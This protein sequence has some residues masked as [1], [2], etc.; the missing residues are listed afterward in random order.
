M[1]RAVVVAALAIAALA[2]HADGYTQG[3]HSASV[4]R[5][6]RARVAPPMPRPQPLHNRAATLLSTLSAEDAVPSEPPRTGFWKFLPPKSE[7]K[8][9][10]PLGLIFFFILFSYTILRDTKDVLV[11][12]APKAGAEIIPFLKVGPRRARAL[13]RGVG[14]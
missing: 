3:V 10:L 14:R 9:I 7:L 6:V 12:T 5:R 13:E 4:L 1:A 2:A 11:V 8:K